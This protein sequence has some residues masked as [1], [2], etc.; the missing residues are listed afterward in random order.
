MP[1]AATGGT[2]PHA[3]SALAPGTRVRIEGSTFGT[4]EGAMVRAGTHTLLLRS[5]A[6]DITVLMRDVKRWL[7]V[8]ETGDQGGSWT[9]LPRNAPPLATGPT[10][11]ALFERGV[12]H[13]PITLSA[14]GAAAYFTLSSG[15]LWALAR[16]P[17]R[18]GVPLVVAIQIVLL[19]VSGWLARNNPKGSSE[20]YLANG[21]LTALGLS[22]IVLA[23]RWLGLF[24]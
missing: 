4:L 24:S 23:S 18:A 3:M 17:S 11:P 8:P 12:R 6:A 21:F 16:G 20:R 10:P 7:A 5:G 15:M 9:P 2:D 14:L 19:G 22:A 1:Q 13:H